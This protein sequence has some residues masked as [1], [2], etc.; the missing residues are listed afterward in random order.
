MTKKSETITITKELLWKSVSGILA[1]LL[2]LAVL[3]GGFGVD[4]VFSSDGA[5]VAQPTAQPSAPSAPTPTAQPVVEVSDDGDPA[6]GDPD[7]PITII[8][9]SDFE[10]PF[11]GRFNSQTL[12]EL[13]KEYIDT[14]KARLVFRDF[15]LSFHA[16]AQKASEAAECANDQGK[17]WEMHDI[18]FENQRALTNSDLKG[19]ASQL[20]LDTAK[21]NNCLDSGEKEA[22]VKAD[23]AAGSKAGVSGTPTFFVNGRKLVGAQPFAAFKAA[24]DAELA[25]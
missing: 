18:I 24:I 14:G 6:K 16:N 25:K 2:L 9:F 20:G 1:V 11:C 19:Y 3:T 7:A 21:F 23:L 10:C 8:E 4:N 12:P 17:F 15:P 5:K 13:Q 22:E